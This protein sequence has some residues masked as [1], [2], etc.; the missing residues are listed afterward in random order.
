MKYEENPYATK[1]KY[2]KIKE[3]SIRLRLFNYVEGWEYWTEE[4]GK[5][6]PCRTREIMDVPSEC[7]KEAKKFFAFV[8]W[9]YESEQTEIWSITQKTIISP[10]VNLY[11]DEDWGKAESLSDFDILVTRK[12]TTLED[13]EYSVTPKPK[14]EFKGELGLVNLEALFRNGD[15]FSTE[16]DLDDIQPGDLDDEG[17]KTKSNK[18]T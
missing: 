10:L 12:G 4:D 6:T 18:K 2:T 1:G 15:P 14:T 9:N 16:L 3:G 17:A 8:V 11:Q 13:T 5:K 7:R